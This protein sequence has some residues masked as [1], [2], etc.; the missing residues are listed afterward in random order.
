[1]PFPEEKPVSKPLTMSELAKLA[2]VSPA[3]FSRIINNHPNV[4][5]ETRLRV[6]KLLNSMNYQ[7]PEVNVRQGRRRSSRRPARYRKMS[8]ALVMNY[9]MELF[10]HLSF[11]NLMQHA[12]EQQLQ[13][14]YYEC[15]L[16]TL[17]EKE[18]WKAI[19]DLKVDG[20]IILNVKHLE[21]A[22]LLKQFMKYPAI[23]ILGTP[24][25]CDCFDRIT[26]DNDGIGKLAAE[27]F[28]N[29]Q[30]EKI[31][32][33]ANTGRNRDSS[34]LYRR[35]EM[36]SACFAPGMVLNADLQD[37]FLDKYLSPLH[38]AYERLLD[39][40]NAMPEKRIGIFAPSDAYIAGLCIEK[41]R[42]HTNLDKTL[43]TL[44]VNNEPFFRN[45]GDPPFPSIDLNVE[46]IA[47]KAVER[48]F[49]RRENPREHFQ[50]FLLPVSLSDNLI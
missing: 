10:S 32:C 22:R 14:V 4:K 1:M 39:I 37:D 36:L 15:V 5:I 46:G 6:E 45:M 40:I 12:I 18:P 35:L 16:R 25:N 31:V 33:F 28:R 9:P 21:N 8:L 43:I 41:N 17:P 30:V 50:S 47:R 42:R 13:N 7:P 29:M 24:S 23:H 48:F 3:T 44:G 27:Y 19:E 20:L 38:P 11:Y 2:G 34:F 49:W 26:Y